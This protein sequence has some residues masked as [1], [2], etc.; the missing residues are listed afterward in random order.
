MESFFSLCLLLIYL[1]ERPNINED[2]TFVNSQAIASVV[3]G[4]IWHITSQKYRA[5][6]LGLQRVLSLSRYETTWQ[7]FHELRRAMVRPCRDQLAVCVQVDETYIGGKNK[8]SK[9]G[10][11]AEGKTLVAIAVVDKG[12]EEIRPI[13][14]QQIPDASADSLGGFVSTMVASRY[15]VKTDDWTRYLTL[16][17]L[18]YHHVTMKAKDLVLL[19]GSIPS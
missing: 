19:F 12:K 10:R 6:A 8:L 4:T 3:S 14:L 1:S 17:S 7:W 11:E 2:S 13:R 15:E 9:R 16:P 5:K 18:G